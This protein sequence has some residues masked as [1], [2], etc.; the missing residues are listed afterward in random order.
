MTQEQ[1]HSYVRLARFWFFTF[2]EKGQG[3]AQFKQLTQKLEAKHREFTTGTTPWYEWQQGFVNLVKKMNSD[4]REYSLTGYDSSRMR[5][6]QTQES[7]DKGIAYI[8][9]H[10]PKVFDQTTSNQTSL[11]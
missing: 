8:S 4:I 3:D 7:M 11:F 10:F 6:K 5:M 9:A 1:F 2:K